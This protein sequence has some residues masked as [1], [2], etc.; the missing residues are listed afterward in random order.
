MPKIHISLLCYRKGKQA[1]EIELIKTVLILD[2]TKGQI[3]QKKFPQ[4]DDIR[5]FTDQTER[6]EKKAGNLSLP[7]SSL[8]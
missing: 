2:W 3:K 4:H 7:K 1:G 8:V 6:P 5:T